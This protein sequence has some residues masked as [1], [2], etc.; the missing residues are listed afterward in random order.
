MLVQAYIAARTG[1]ALSGAQRRRLDERLTVLQGSL[2]EQQYLLHLQSPSGAA[3]LSTLISVVAVHKTDLF[4]DEVQLQDFRAHVLEPLVSKSLG[5]PL[6]VWSAGCAT[7]EE[8]ATLLIM[9]DE[10]RAD[11]GST[12]LGTDISEAALNRART[13]SFPGEQVRRLPGSL[14]ERYFMPDGSRAILIPELRERAIFQHHNLM[15]TPYPTPSG[16]GGEGFDVIF[17]RNVLIY[18]TPEAFERVVSALAERL[19]PGG[20]LILSAAEPLLHAPPS[21]RIIRSQHAFFYVRTPDMSASQGFRTAGMGLLPHEL[22]VSGLERRRETVPMTGGLPQIPPPDW[23]REA[24]TPSGTPPAPGSEPRKESGR[25]AAVGGSE[26]RRDSG[27][28]ASVGG[29]SELRRDSGRFP[30][31]G[32][33]SE[34]QSRDSGRFPSVGSTEPQRDSGR[35]PSV[36]GGS[37]L[38]RDSGRYPSVGGGSEPRPRDSGRYPSVG[39]STELRRDSGRFPSVGAAPAQGGSPSSGQFPTVKPSESQERQEE[40][41]LFAEADSLFTQV[42]EGVAESDS[43]TEDYLRRCLALD[44][45]LSAARYLLAMLLELRESFADAAAEYRK[46]L[47]SL[48]EGRARPTPFFLNHARLR[49]ACEKAIARMEGGGGRPR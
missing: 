9:L 43:Q 42:L 14:R 5:R 40:Q 38:R 1:M 35:F 39:G 34:P 23:A 11:Q 32:G 13:L 36:G 45:D 44:P 48:E 3:D 37:E 7:G 49:V 15:E 31:V 17:C 19:A 4:R 2:S 21:L 18:F 26:T 16:G 24:G 20:T 33:G 41:P 12:V 47:R 8:V 22:P 28:L 27:R 46:A 30:S 10:A 29:G 6:R 25:F